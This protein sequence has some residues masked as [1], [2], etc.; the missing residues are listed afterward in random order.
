MN[1]KVKE[2][3]NKY[4]WE[5]DGWN[6]TIRLVPINH[7]KG[8]GNG[9]CRFYEI[10]L[11]YLMTQQGKELPDKYM[12]E[13]DETTKDYDLVKKTEEKKPGKLYYDFF[14][15]PDEYMTQDEIRPED[16]LF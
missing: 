15:L 5:V 1:N 7:R 11:K 14:D 10:K 12:W 16:M 3:N 9:Y 13:I 8:N 6:K 2:L 4:M